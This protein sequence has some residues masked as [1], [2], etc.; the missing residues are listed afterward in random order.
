MAFTVQAADGSV[1]SANSYVSVAAVRAYWLDRAIDL[2]T[3]TDAQIEAAA[4][5]ATDYLDAKYKWVG[6]QLRTTQ[7]T[8]WPRGS[9][10]TRLAG[11]P[12]ALL[13]AACAL[14]QRALTK[15]LMPDPTVDA[16]GLQVTEA[17]KTVGPISVTTKFTSPSANPAASVPDY[18]EVSLMLSA[19]GMVG[20]SNSGELSRG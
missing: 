19:A 17:T 16:S 3:Y 4:V 12:P 20:S 14:A 11:L 6:Y 10:S 18:P 1:D 2:S 5:K 15:S 7:G 13:N 9:V 8:Q